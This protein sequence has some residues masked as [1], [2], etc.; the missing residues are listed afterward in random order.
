MN[1]FVTR[2]G[3][4]SE[5]SEYLS[6][7]SNFPLLDEETE[8]KLAR[9]AKAGDVSA[10]ELLIVSNLRLVVSIAK[11]YPVIGDATRMDLIQE[12]NL[13]LINAVNNFDVDMG[14]RFST[15]ATSCIR[16]A[17]YASLPSNY[18][19]IGLPLY[20]FDSLVKMNRKIKECEALGIEFSD[21]ELANYLDVSVDKVYLLKQVATD[22]FSL[23]TE[24]GDEKDDYL[25]NLI[26]SDIN[27]E[28][29]FDKIA[30]C[31]EIEDIFKEFS[32]DEVKIM[33]L[34]L[35]FDG[36]PKTLGE[37]AKVIGVSRER[38]RQ[39]ESKVLRRLRLPKYSSRLR[40]YDD[41]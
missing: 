26:P 13:G 8:K 20:L 18:R 29:E 15:Y 24:I 40:V 5:L 22:V 9:L 6:L 34:R 17:I 28:D 19:M 10:K 2:F 4:V 14:Y 12:G 16:R 1:D 25:L 38:I 32:P 39:I 31:E 41:K 33:K 37:I 36:E 7:I 27:V 23:Q 35:G 30:F 3:N 21:E 11:N